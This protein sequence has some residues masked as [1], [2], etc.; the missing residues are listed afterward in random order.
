MHAAKVCPDL[1]NGVSVHRDAD[2]DADSHPDKTDTEYRV[3]TADDL[4]DGNKCSDEVI[5]KN[6]GQPYSCL[7]ERSCHALLREELDQKA[8][9][10]YC[11]YSTD[12]D[13]KHDRENTHDRLHDRTKVDANDLRDR[14]TVVSL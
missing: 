5:N 10:A 12:H 7:S 6:D 9:R 8:C 4:V 11:K 3:N 14:R 2:A 13:Q 1:R